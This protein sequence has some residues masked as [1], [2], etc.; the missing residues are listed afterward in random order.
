MADGLLGVANTLCFES[1]GGEND[2]PD[3]DR[4]RPYRDS[5]PSPD[6]GE[7]QDLAP[8]FRICVDE[9][10]EEGENGLGVRELRCFPRTD[11]ELEVTNLSPLEVV[12]AA[13]LP[14]D[15]DFDADLTPDELASAFVCPN[16]ENSAS[17]PAISDAAANCR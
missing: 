11:F 14:E 15:E 2:D 8:T 1:D 9:R 3:K 7:A 10:T 4:D 13:C 12:E 6:G 5:E 16:D 17:A